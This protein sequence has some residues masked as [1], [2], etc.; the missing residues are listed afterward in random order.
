MKGHPRPCPRLPPR[1]LILLLSALA[2]QLL[3]ALLKRLASAFSCLSLSAIVASLPRCSCVTILSSG[4]FQERGLRLGF[5]ALAFVIMCSCVIFRLPLSAATAFAASSALAGPISGNASA[6]CRLR[7]FA[8][9]S[10]I[11]SGEIFGGTSLSRPV[12]QRE[13]GLLQG[14]VDELRLL[15]RARCAPATRLSSCH[16]VAALT[17]WQQHIGFI[18]CP[19][20]V[21][22]LSGKPYTTASAIATAR[23]DTTR[24]LAPLPVPAIWRCSFCGAIAALVGGTCRGSIPDSYTCLP[25]LLMTLL[26]LQVLAQ[27]HRSTA[28]CVILR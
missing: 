19:G 5:G 15:T 10:A 22:P 18:V 27:F 17:P 3:S 26:P 21:I 28:L 2:M 20:C 7:L 16:S 11:C 25:F 4:P 12:G 9:A 1:P 23:R 6:S 13:N 14:I 24:I 8:S